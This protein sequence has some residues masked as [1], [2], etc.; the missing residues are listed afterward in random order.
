MWVPAW[1]EYLGTD[2]LTF[3]LARKGSF[4]LDFDPD[5]MNLVTWTAAK[6]IWIAIDGWMTAST[7][8]SSRS[9][10]RLVRRVSHSPI[11]RLGGHR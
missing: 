9:A 1:V 3:W 10:G 7:G 5:H 8:A 6:P 2:D 4:D 11:L